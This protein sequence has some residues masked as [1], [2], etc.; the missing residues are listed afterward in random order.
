MVPLRQG[1]I[2]YGGVAVAAQQLKAYPDLK[3]L[4][5]GMPMEKAFRAALE[6]A[7]EMGWQIVAQVPAEGRIE[8]TDTSFWYGFKDDVVIRIYPAGDRSL[9]DIRSVS[10][11]GVSDVGVNAK[12]IRGFLA[13]I[14]HQPLPK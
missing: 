2:E 14:S 5:L 11:V 3:T 1:L 9:V 6:T 8:A 10:R 12:R 13:K 7:R 4:L